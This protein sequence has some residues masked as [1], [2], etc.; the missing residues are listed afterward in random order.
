MPVKQTQ[1]NSL[2]GDEISQH[3]ENLFTKLLLRTHVLK[4]E[5]YSHGM[6]IHKYLNKFKA[7]CSNM[8]IIQDN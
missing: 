1:L 2:L 7:F 6:D 8:N 5:K 3:F 4:P